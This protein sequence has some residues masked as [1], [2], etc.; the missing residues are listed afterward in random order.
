MDVH[1]LNST[2]SLIE[3]TPLSQ[4][5]LNCI[6]Q[7]D[8]I[9][10]LHNSNGASSSSSHTQPSTIH[11]FTKKK[12]FI[13]HTSLGI[14]LM[15]IYHTL[16]ED[17][18]NTNVE[19]DKENVF[20][21]CP[22]QTF[23]DNLPSDNNKDDDNDEYSMKGIDIEY[24]SEDEEQFDNSSLTSII[25]N[26]EGYFDISDPVIECE[27]CGACM[28]YQERKRKH[29]NTTSPKYELCCGDDRIQISLLRAPP[30]IPQHILFD[31]KSNDSVNY[32]NNIRLY[33]MMFEFTS[34]GAKIDRSINNG[35]GPPTIRIQC[36][37]NHVIVLVTCCLCRDNFQSFPNYIFMIPNMKLK[38]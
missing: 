27:Y 2:H 14:N 32:Q 33:N 22:S 36:K 38:I 11:E 17:E 5:S 12:T 30:P 10:S 21:F 25:G 37:D 18:I 35:R 31:L 24:S 26:E 28:W 1:M 19:K 6:N 9:Y 7:R 20:P 3:R 34:L 29:R 4:I 8:R 15:N 16:C 23:T 13:N